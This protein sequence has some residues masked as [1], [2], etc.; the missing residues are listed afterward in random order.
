MYS[1]LL[2]LF[3]VGAAPFCLILCDFVHYV[4][5]FC[6]P[7]PLDGTVVLLQMFSKLIKDTEQKKHGKVVGLTGRYCCKTLEVNYLN[8]LQKAAFGGVRLVRTE[9]VLTLPP[10][11]GKDKQWLK[12]SKIR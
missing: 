3:W 7:W 6:Q 1:L 4:G 12:S 10:L 5:S 2:L 9:K 11:E 8:Q